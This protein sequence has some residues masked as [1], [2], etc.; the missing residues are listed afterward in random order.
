MLKMILA[1]DEPVILR[2]IKKLINWTGLGIEIIGEYEDGKSALNAIIGSKPDIALLDICMPF[3]NGIDILKEIRGIGIE[4]IVVFISGYQDFEYAK[5]ALKYGAADYLLK[6]VIKEELT[7]AFEKVVRQ[8]N[9]FKN[10]GYFETVKDDFKTAYEKLAK[11]EESKYIPV[12]INIFY[13]Y[14]EDQYEK[15][16]V[17]FSIASCIENYLEEKGFG[18][19]FIKDGH[20]VLVL[21][22]MEKNIAKTIIVELIDIVWHKTKYKVGAVIGRL[23]NSMGEIPEEYLEC[24]SM[25]RYFF[26]AEKLPSFILSVEESIFPNNLCTENLSEIGDKIIDEIISQSDWEKH[27]EKFS[28]VLVKVSD[29][30]K[31][32]ACFYFCE[33][34]RKLEEK[35]KVAG[36]PRV[37]IDVKDLLAQSRL[38]NNYSLMLEFFKEHIREYF[39]KI[40]TVISNSDKKYI[41]VAKEYIEKHYK[42]DLTLEILAKQV[43][44]NPYYFSSFFKKHSGEN[45]K[46]YLNKIRLEHALFELVSTDK[47]I[48]EISYGVGFRDSRS[49]TKLF[50]KTYGESPV[51][52]RKRAKNNS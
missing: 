2:G 17:L 25:I 20:V 30:K 50:Q 12:I 37:G 40:K 27:F 22:S 21:K 44:M 49:F 46:D 51:E 1:D 39:N 24:I 18:I 13:K 31:E 29:G 33:L 34:V 9:G 52:Y 35:F 26:F 10:N 41:I 14:E 16:L 38:I 36:L 11:I 19:A 15:K 5:D 32:D 3:K 45:F 43:H 7:S 28:D 8:L 6:P 47:K 23:L 48:Y 42:E 4:T